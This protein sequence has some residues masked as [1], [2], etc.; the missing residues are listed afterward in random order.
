MTVRE[1]LAIAVSKF[2][3][4]LSSWKQPSRICS[5]FYELV[6]QAKFNWDGPAVPPMVSLWLSL[7]FGL[8]WGGFPHSL[9]SSRSQ[10]RLFRITVA[11]FPE[12]MHKLSSCLCL[13]NICQCSAGQSKSHH[14]ESPLPV[15]LWEGRLHKGLDMGMC[16]IVGMLT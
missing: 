15:P 9:P 12:A 6:V 4:K 5:Q 1:R 11:E 3:P 13:H 14:W 2:I 10:L 8:N 7:V 16:D